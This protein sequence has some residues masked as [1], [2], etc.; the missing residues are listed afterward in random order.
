VS[1]LRNVFKSD[2]S[3]VVNSG[4]SDSEAAVQRAFSQAQRRNI[5][6]VGMR[7][8][9][10]IKSGALLLAVRMRQRWVGERDGS[11]DESEWCVCASA[12]IIHLTRRAPSS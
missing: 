9:C 10:I 7:A 12:E 3:K 1:L 5:F 8:V 4:V 11:W 6:K 2:D